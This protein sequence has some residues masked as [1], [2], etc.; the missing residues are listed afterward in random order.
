[1]VSASWD[2]T[3][4]VWDAE[5]GDHLHTL[6]GHEAEVNSVLFTPDGSRIVSASEDDTIRIWDSRTHELQRTIP[7]DK[8]MCL[9][10]SPDGKTLITG[11]KESIRLRNL[12]AHGPSVPTK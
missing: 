11:G 7:T 8:V 10:I 6:R 12:P 5:T 2:A 3:L 9:A 1:M 4:R